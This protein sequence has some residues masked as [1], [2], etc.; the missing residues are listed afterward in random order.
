VDKAL[1]WLEAVPNLSEGR[2]RDWVDS[3][4]ERVSA[5]DDVYLLDRSS[6]ADHHRSVF[7]LVGLPGALEAALLD[8]AE[9]VVERIDLAEHE[10]VHPRVG[11]LDVVPF[12]PLGT[13]PMSTAVATAHRWGQTMAE[14]LEVP[15]FAYGDAARSPGRKRLERIRVGGL[16]G[17]EGR[18]AE[19]AARRSTERTGFAGDEDPPDELDWTPDWGPA[20]PHR[21]AGATVVGARDFLLAFNVLLETEDLRIAKQVAR[22]VRESSGGIPT[23]KAIGIPLRARGRVQV[24]LN[25]TDYRVASPLQV[26]D[27]VAAEAASRGVGI[28]SSE[29]IGLFPRAALD[30]RDTERLKLENPDPHGCLEDRLRRLGIDIGSTPS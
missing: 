8:L 1:S 7:T 21:T 26:F 11:A 12:I 29:R 25:L 20:V 13:T 17:L 30:G 22:A 18:M 19:A 24:S 4:A 6:D 2:D 23:V 16:V 9:A 28:H 5:R 27:R 3:I 10:G 14:R 15:V